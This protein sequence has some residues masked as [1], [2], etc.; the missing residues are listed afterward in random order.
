VRVTNESMRELTDQASLE[1]ITT[2]R[3]VEVHGSGARA[4][5]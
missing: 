5:C 2:S 3:T 1:P 4:R